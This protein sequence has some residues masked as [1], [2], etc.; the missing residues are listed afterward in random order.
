M[1]EVGVIASNNIG[2][3]WKNNKKIE[4]IWLANFE[5][6]ISEREKMDIRVEK[7]PKQK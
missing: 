2:G 5:L 7:F 1:V 6:V 4:V 3:D